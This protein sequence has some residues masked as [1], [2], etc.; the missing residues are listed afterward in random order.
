[1]LE[2]MLSVKFRLEKSKNKSNKFQKRESQTFS[3][4]NPK[5]EMLQVRVF[6]KV[7]LQKKPYDLDQSDGVLPSEKDRNLENLTFL[8]K[9]QLLSKIVLTLAMIKPKL[10]RN[11][12]WT[13]TQ[14]IEI[15][16]HS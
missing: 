2:K 11:A 15:S 12:V 7:S 16:N 10:L 8:R 14:M 9:P 3:A 13:L 5:Q 1:M 6:P 4:K